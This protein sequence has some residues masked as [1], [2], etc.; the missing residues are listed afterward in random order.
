[1]SGG[2]TPTRAPVLAIARQAR[3]DEAAQ[4]LPARQARRRTARSAGA[5]QRHASASR[6][7]SPTA[8]RPGAAAAT[9]RRLRGRRVAR[10]FAA[11]ASA[12]T[13]AAACRD[14]AAPTATARASRRSSISRTTSPP[15]TSPRGARGLPLDRARQALHHDRHGDRPGQDLATCNALG[16]RRRRARQGRCPQ[17]GLT[18]FRPPYTP[19]TFG[20]FAGHAR[21]DL[22]DPIAHDADPR[23]GRGARRRVRGCR[24]VE[25]RL[26]LPA[27][28]RGHARGGRPRVPRGARRRRHVRRLDARQDRGR[29]AR[30]RPSSSNRIYTNA[31]T[32][33]E[34]GRC[35][36]GLM[37]RE[38]GFI[39]RRRRHRP[40]RAGPLPRDHHDRRRAA[41][42]RHMEDYL[43]T[44]WPDLKVWLTSTTEQWAVIAVQG[45]NAR[46]V[47]APLV[48]GIDLV[49]RAP[50][51]TCRVRE[52]T[53]CGVPTRL[54][55]VSFTGELG[56]E[57]NVPAD[58]GRAVWEA[59]C[60]AGPGSTASRPTAPRPCTCCA[61]RRATSSSARRPTAR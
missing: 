22:F 38:D 30:T 9:R 37:L 7:R 26:V 61:P 35:R 25:A 28:R 27:G 6:R 21:G 19:V 10:R 23:L 42:A 41:R 14:A 45:P 16:D 13:P 31:W 40:P 17:V 34:P 44:E 49:A 2:W 54:F 24:P 46:E 56:F 12:P 57:V 18:T 4:T 47:L 32:K 8:P 1:M 33:L 59:L 53:I 11:S 15:R 43:Q 55:R 51:R 39:M 3:F 48:E 58:Y 50:C 60:E 52:G 5:V 20:A 29:R 36:Y